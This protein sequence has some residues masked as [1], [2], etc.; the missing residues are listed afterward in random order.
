MLPNNP[1]QSLRTVPTNE[2]IAL[3]LKQFKRLLT[4]RDIK[5]TSDELNSISVAIAQYQV[6][7]KTD[8]IQKALLELVAES[9]T[10]LQERFGLTFAEALATDMNGIGGWET[11]AEF[12]EIANHKSNAELR[13]SAG[14]SL[15]TLTGNAQFVEHLWAVIAEDAGVWDVDASIAQRAL[16]HVADVDPQADDWEPQVRAWLA[17]QEAT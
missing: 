16:T 6:T 14:S 7:P 5:L 3:L 11:T 15:L 4:E 9:E 2:L 12:L 13:I 17:A 8:A 10:V 1:A